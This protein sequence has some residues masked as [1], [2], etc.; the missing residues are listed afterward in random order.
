VVVFLCRN[1]AQTDV[2]QRHNTIEMWNVSYSLCFCRCLICHIFLHQPMDWSLLFDNYYTES[3]WWCDC[4][5]SVLNDSV[6]WNKTPAKE[7][8]GNFDLLWVLEPSVLIFFRHYSTAK[9]ALVET[10]SCFSV[11]SH[12]LHG[13]KNWRYSDCENVKQ[14][15]KTYLHNARSSA[16]R[17]WHIITYFTAT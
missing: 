9:T 5:S 17:Q 13:V 4:D 16:D 15:R 2:M 11:C 7:N 3:C 10:I 14:H 12:F 8:Y 1:L 6:R